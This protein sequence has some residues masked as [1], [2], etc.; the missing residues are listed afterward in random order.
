MTA[1]TAGIHFKFEI[2]FPVR[3]ICTLAPVGIVF[4]LFAWLGSLTGIVFCW[5]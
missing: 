2:L 5:P 1:S 3:P 4:N